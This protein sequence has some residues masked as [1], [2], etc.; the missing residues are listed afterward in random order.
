MILSLVGFLEFNF[1]I[2]HNEEEAIFI[3]KLASIWITIPVYLLHFV[4]VYTKRKN[5]ER[6][7]FY[8]L[9]FHIP[10][11]IFL[12]HDLFTQNISGIPVKSYFGWAR[13]IRS[14][15]YLWI[16]WSFITLSF[17]IA[18]LISNYRKQKNPILKKQVRL[19]SIGIILAFGVIVTN[20]SLIKFTD[21]RLPDLIILGSLIFT[22]FICFGIY[23]Y[24][25]F[26]ISAINAADK[27]LN[28]IQNVVILADQYG[29]IVQTNNF[30]K[31]LLPEK[32]KLEGKN[33]D[34]VFEPIETN[35]PKLT[36][37]VKKDLKEKGIIKNLTYKIPL[38]KNQ[39]ILDV[40]LSAKFERENEILAVV[41]NGREITDYYQEQQELMHLNSKLEELNKQ[42]ITRELEMIDIKNKLRSKKN[43]R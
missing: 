20:K 3:L 18:L 36:S 5:I 42:M 25:L 41:I 26:Q 40:T 22:T 13:D 2:A 29:D 27:I 7:P 28:S 33:I 1:L 16:L 17:A 6:S 8:Y 9:I 32:T 24:K 37:I 19:I 39:I 10:S 43:E 12:A 4:I 21:E 38:K 14:D 23:K 35:H 34:D 30:T 11:I 15:N 31:K